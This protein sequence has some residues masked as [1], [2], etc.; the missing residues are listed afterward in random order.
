MLLL[1][2]LLFGIVSLGSPSSAPTTSSS[3]P[4]T[5]VAPLNEDLF[6]VLSL[7]EIYARWPLYG[8]AEDVLQ[9]REWITRLSERAQ[10]YPAIAETYAGLANLS[11][12][13]ERMVVEAGVLEAGDGERAAVW[14]DAEQSRIDGADLRRTIPNEIGAWFKA[15]KVRSAQSRRARDEFSKAILM[16]MQ[17]AEQMAFKFADQTGIAREATGFSGRNGDLID[18]VASHRRDPYTI[19]AFGS[20]PILD[21]SAK[22]RSYGATLQSE[23]AQLIPRTDAYADWRLT[24]HDRA[25][26]LAVDACSLEWHDGTDEFEAKSYPT[27]S[28]ERAVEI[29][30]AYLAAFDTPMSRYNLAQALNYGDEPQAAIEHMDL[31]DAA[32]NGDASLNRELGAEV[33]YGAA[34][35]HSLVGNTE[36]ALARLLYSLEIARHRAGWARVDPDLEAVRVA[37]PTEFNDATE[38]RWS[39]GV[40][41]G[42]EARLVFVT[43]ESEFTLHDVILV[44]NLK[45]GETVELG[46]VAEIVE[47]HAWE[48]PDGMDV[49]EL[50]AVLITSELH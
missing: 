7:R 21:N 5:D 16:G 30:R 24:L 46:P 29:C 12:Q 10:D 25:T 6:L 47:E 37:Y 32:F 44:I 49:S 23:A 28:A 41:S 9:H 34:C 8:T 3:T 17:S 13:Y 1:S 42:E 20:R 45:S 19:Y 26:A 22:Y 36:K 40:G 38:V 39:W 50:S 43:N 48:L 15:E 11:A 4:T 18:Q 14:L 2:C 33:A 35:L 31:A 27:P